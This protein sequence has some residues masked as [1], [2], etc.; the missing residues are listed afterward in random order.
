MKMNGNN[1][2]KTIQGFF[3]SVILTIKE[4]KTKTKNIEE[5]KK[6]DDNIMIIGNMK[7]NPLYFTVYSSTTKYTS[8][9]TLTDS[10]FKQSSSTICPLFNAFNNVVYHTGR[11]YSEKSKRTEQNLLKAIY[12]WYQM[13]PKKPLESLKF[14]FEPI[15]TEKNLDN[16]KLLFRSQYYFLDQEK[17]LAY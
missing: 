2:D 14:I 4:N 11:Y 7:A 1:I 13:K 17:Q 8:D 5:Q 3:D 10:G 16:L 6:I 12:V 15:I 9:S